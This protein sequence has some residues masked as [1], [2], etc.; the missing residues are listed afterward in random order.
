MIALMNSTILDGEWH[1]ISI[2]FSSPDNP[3]DNAVI[4]SYDKMEVPQ[5]NFTLAHSHQ[6]LRDLILSPNAEIVVGSSL[7]TSSDPGHSHNQ[8]YR[9]CLR[10]VYIGSY[11]LP[12]IS[13]SKLEEVNPK[14][15]NRSFIEATAPVAFYINEVLHHSEQ[16]LPR[17]G[18]I[19]CYEKDCKNA[20]H[21]TDPTQSY[22]CTCAPGYD[23]ETCDVRKLKNMHIK[24][25]CENILPREKLIQLFLIFQRDI[26]ECVDNRC[27][28]G[29]TCIDIVNNYTCSCA[30]GYDGW[31]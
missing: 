17:L 16:Q 11:R 2:K 23:G 13:P 25:N 8:Y 14:I 24:K 27:S 9:G 21:C 30:K 19:L 26:D 6:Y 1:S 10:D 4:L 28:H 5:N 12:F 31:L 20:G 18:C 22:D 7:T 3:V 29:S 15:T